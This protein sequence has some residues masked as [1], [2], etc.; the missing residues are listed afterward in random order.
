MDQ[1]LDLKLNHHRLLLQDKFVLLSLNL[2]L[3]LMV[4]L[5]MNYKERPYPL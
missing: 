4:K 3:R 2:N 1:V 5:Y